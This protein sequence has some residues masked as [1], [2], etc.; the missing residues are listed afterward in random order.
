M[1]RTY[2]QKLFKIDPAFMIDPARTILTE[3]IE[4]VLAEA[5]VAFEYNQCSDLWARV[6]LPLASVYTGC[7]ALTFQRLAERPDGN[8]RRRRCCAQHQKEVS[9]YGDWL[10]VAPARQSRDCLSEVCVNEQSRRP[11]GT[12]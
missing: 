7:S 10:S 9:S 2:L 3:M 1:H 8:W 12:E 6:N 4:M 11:W 5:S